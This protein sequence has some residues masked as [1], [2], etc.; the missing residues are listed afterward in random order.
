MGLARLSTA[1]YDYVVLDVETNGLR[2]KEH[3]LL[4]ISLYKPDDGKEYNRFLPLD[5]NEGVYTTHINGISECDLEGKPH[6]SQVELDELFEVFELDR[7]TILHF[8]GKDDLFL[9]NY[10][11]RHG[12]FGYNRMHFFNF[13]R[14]IC[15]TKFSDGSLTKDRLCEMFGIEG[16]TSV[17]SGANDCRLEWKLFEAFDGHYLLATMKAFH[18]QISVLDPEYVVPVSYLETFP[19]LSRLY[20]RP[21]IGFEMQEIYR[22]N[23]SGDSIRRFESNFS[24]KTIEY[25]INVMLGAE[26]QDNSAFLRSNY[27]KN[28]LLGRMRHDTRPV[29]VDFNPDGTVAVLREEDNQRERELNAAL[30]EMKQQLAPLVEYIHGDIFVGANIV[31]QELVVNEEMRIMALCDFSSD[32]AVLEVKTSSL[33]PEQYAEQLYY[34][35]KGR[36]TYLLTMEWGTG[37][38]DFVINDVNVYPGEKPNGRREKAISSLS[39]VLKSERL[40]VVNYA[41]STMPVKVRC[42]KCGYEWEESY[43]HIKSGKCVCPDCHPDRYIWKKKKRFV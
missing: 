23:V 24:G 5:L 26:M 30:T 42:E 20:E 6:L 29:F 31:A 27:Q 14:M 10:F 43:Y 34:E 7:R 38:V 4:S 9:K 16:V 28:R 12:L 3:D 15:S 2:S 18:W 40:E 19:N 1:P 17:H 41:K 11:A 22:L 32:T 33:D 37:S 25:L 36:K 8:G 39:A 13:K 35:S 21:H